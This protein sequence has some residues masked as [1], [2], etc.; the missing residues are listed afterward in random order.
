MSPVNQG[1]HDYL[2]EFVDEGVI[3]EPQVG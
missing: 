2:D 1:G 3:I